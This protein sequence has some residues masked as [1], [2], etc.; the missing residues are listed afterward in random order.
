MTANN[1][2]GSRVA[3]VA[4]GGNA[5]SPPGGANT[6]TDQFRHTRKS[7]DG[8]LALIQDGYS[9]AITHGNGPQIG[10]ALLRQELSRERVPELPLGVLVASTEGWM[11]YMIEQS[12]L[13][14]MHGE[15]IEKQVAS[16]VTQVLVDKDD[17][18]LSDPS[19]FVGQSYP[20]Y[21]AHR[22]AKLFGWTVKHDRARDGWR[23]V[24]GSPT[25]ISVVNS[26]AIKSLVEQDWVVICAGGGGVPVYE[27][28]EYGL[29]GL[30][31]VI[32]KDRASAVLANDISASDYIIL[33]EV[34]KVSL[35][36]GRTDQI[37][38]KTMTISEAKEY[39]EIGHFPPGSMGPK[40]E[41][42]I[43][44]LEGGGERAIITNLE[45][46]VDALNGKAGTTITCD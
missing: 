41:S 28:E 46:V 39:S 34:E 16:I 9:L 8:I 11:G 36:F 12:L 22:L 44:F 1:N 42:A 3:V 4:L 29:D 25:P 37:D 15:G 13:N 35:N 33:T 14:R 20:E 2:S 26:D 24:V 23:R 30:D 5:I 32:D 17:P 7:L 31:A 6:I 18:S 21:E 45:N 10:N 40:I 38:L 19:K 27:H 43:S